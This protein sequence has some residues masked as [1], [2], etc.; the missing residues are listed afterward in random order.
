MTEVIGG[1]ERSAEEA[2]AVEAAEVAGVV[3]VTTEVVFWR[4]EG[5]DLEGREAALLVRLKVVPWVVAGGVDSD[6]DTVVVAAAA[7]SAILCCM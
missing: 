2:T 7:A 3:V 1:E 6:V 4:L 5:L